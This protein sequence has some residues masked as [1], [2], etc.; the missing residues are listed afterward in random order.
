MGAGSHAAS[1]KTIRFVLLM[2]PFV[3]SYARVL[4]YRHSLTAV[5]HPAVIVVTIPNAHLTTPSVGA[6]AWVVNS[7]HYQMAVGP[8][9]V[10][11]VMRLIVPAQMPHASS[12]A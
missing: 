2:M 4:P 3:V 8:H 6:S 12:F 11:A 5:D 10:I 7:Q 9:A 1:A